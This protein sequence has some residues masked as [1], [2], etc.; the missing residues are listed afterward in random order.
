MTEKIILGSAQFGLVY[1][2]TNTTGLLPL[3]KV[4]EITK[5]AADNGVK[6]IDT[7]R[8]YGVAEER[9]GK[10]FEDD[11]SL[12][13]SINIVTKLATF[14]GIDLNM[15]ERIVNACQANCQLERPDCHANRTLAVSM[16][17]L[18]FCFCH[19]N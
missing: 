3:E 1:G 13:E 2:R 10:I 7:A 6:Y 11:P 15:D 16:T 14:D 8:A 9:F 17:V 12:N 19:V 5:F 18:I 4:A